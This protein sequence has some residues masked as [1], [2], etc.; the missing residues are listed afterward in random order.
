MTDL[1][2]LT[3]EFEQLRD[4]ISCLNALLEPGLLANGTGVRS[5]VV[6][7]FATQP[8]Q[9]A[10]SST[11]PVAQVWRT[12]TS[13][14]AARAWTTLT[15]WVDWLV[16]RY[17]LDD[18][19]PACWYRHGAIVDELDALRAAW[20]GSYLDGSAQLN[21]PALWLDLLARALA[22]IRDWD[23]YGCAA[24]THREDAEV[25]PDETTRATRDTYLH[26]DIHRR[27]QAARSVS[28]TAKSRR[29]NRPANPVGLQRAARIQSADPSARNDQ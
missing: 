14:E 5:G 2:R 12:L 25:A 9:S 19:L 22:R 18:T 4:E 27:A 24:G 23:R 21:Y 1:R 29:T 15:S 8:Q 3:A 26:A 10:T 16:A 7:G 28:I 20:A 6:S 17:Q 11:R 13:T